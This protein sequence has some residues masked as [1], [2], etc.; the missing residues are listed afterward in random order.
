MWIDLIRANASNEAI[1]SVILMDG[2]EKIHPLLGL[3]ACRVLF[4]AEGLGVWVF[5]GLLS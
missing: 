5:N 1:L 3:L 2:M 4:S